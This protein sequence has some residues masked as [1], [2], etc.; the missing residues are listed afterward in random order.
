VSLHAL[1][2]SASRSASDDAARIL[3]RTHLDGRSWQPC[4]AAAAVIDVPSIVSG[5]VELRA[6]AAL[7]IAQTFDVLDADRSRRAEALVRAALADSADAVLE[8]ADADDRLAWCIAAAEW[9]ERNGLDHAFA[10][11]E[12][13]AAADD[14][15][16]AVWARVHWRIAA[17]WHHEAFCRRG[18]CD[19]LLAEAEAIADGADE[20]GLRVNAWLARARLALSRSAPGTAVALARR[21]ADEADP[22]TAPLW[23]ADVADIEARSA[24]LVGDMHRALH[25]ARQATALGERA[26][27]PPAYTMTYRLYEAYALLGLGAYDDAVALARTLAAIALPGWLTARIGLLA[28]LFALVRA[29]RSGPWTD[30]ET[31]VLAAA[32]ARLRTLDWPGVLAVLPAAVAGLWA[33][34][35]DAGIE[36]AWIR[37]S[38]SARQLDPPEGCVSEDW[39]WAVRV[40][41]LGSFVCTSEGQELA[42]PGKTAAKPL[43]LLRRL[44]VEGG[45]DGMAAEM[46]AEALWPGEGREGRDKALE[47]TLARLRR[48]LGHADAVLVQERRLRLNPKRVWVDRIALDQVLDRL[49]PVGGTDASA[50]GLLWSRAF[51]LLRG[52]LLAGEPDDEWL[53]AAR[54]RLRLRMGAALG[55][56]AADDGHAQRCLRID[57]VDPGAVA[58]RRAAGDVVSP[59]T[60]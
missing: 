24:L 5:P 26:G 32:V 47:V 16:A 25:R 27:A 35:L 41:V 36:T 4:V 17:A 33:R 8:G 59:P 13:V 15:R 44:A 23:L 39:P 53:A 2:R 10:R 31:A 42:R 56:T 57:G 55:A 18:D 30:R 22:R 28:Q 51:S 58:A 9:C 38:I 50:R 37:A 7:A 20:I 19:A 40:R 54:R 12:A 48:L 14:A 34:A 60:S 6:V 45:F 52:P 46:L 3:L 1:S 21:A 49:P 29:D 43:A 11:L